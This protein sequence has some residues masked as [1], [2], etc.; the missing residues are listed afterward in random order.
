MTVTRKRLASSLLL[1]LTNNNEQIPTIAK[2]NETK[3][4]IS[5]TSGANS[6]IAETATKNSEESAILKR[7]GNPSSVTARTLPTQAARAAVSGRVRIRR[8]PS[9]SIVPFAKA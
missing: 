7:L 1:E 5:M 3:L 6:G 8:Y 4:S 2:V 9:F